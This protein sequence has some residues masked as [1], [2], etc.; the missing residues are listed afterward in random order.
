M[1]LRRLYDAFAPRLLG[2]ARRIL[3]RPS[4]AEEVI[5]DSFLT[6]WKRAGDYDPER[7]SVESWLFM[8]V[9]H[10]SIDRLRAQN[11]RSNIEVQWPE[12]SSNII[13]FSQEDEGHDFQDEPALRALRALPPHQ[14][15]PL[16]LAFFEGHT[17]REI[18]QIVNRPLG[19]IKSEIRRALARLRKGGIANV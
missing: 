16:E 8:I 14:R 6:V 9:R 11:R 1:A 5:Q 2:L 7:A 12:H 13:A 19:T 10:K 15:E 4:D 17:H 18:A 3:I